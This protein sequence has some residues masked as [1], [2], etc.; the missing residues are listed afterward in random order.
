MS[1]FSPSASPVGLVGYGR[2]GAAFA[3]L[4]QEAGVRVW[5]LDPNG[6]PEH[7][8]VGSWAE[9][10][11]RAKTL[12]LATP[13]P[14]FEG[15]L[16]QL[17]PHLSAEHLV[18]DVGSVKEAPQAVLQQVL[19]STVPWVATHPLFGPASLARAER[20]IRVVVCPNPLHPTAH[21]RARALYEHVGCEV[22]EDDAAS[23][24]R[25]MADTHALTFF[26]TKGILEAGLYQDGRYAPPSFAAIERTLETVRADAGHLFLAIQHENPYAAATRKRL[27]EALSKVDQDL[28]ETEPGAYQGMDIPDLGPRT[29]QEPPDLLEEVDRELI[30]LLSRR[31]KLSKR[32][33]LD[34]AQRRAI[35]SERAA[36]AEAAGLEPRVIHAVLRAIWDT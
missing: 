1:G 28:Q 33:E 13:V 32:A 4:L 31:A 20:P 35:L 16:L 25:L 2:F 21:P 5:A 27:V 24:D 10:T 19:G 34:P 11:S 23:H 3:D 17:Q 14:T 26:V 29:S 30:A 12:V 15:V 9:L 36:Q 7:R 6:V 8:A 22:I 18:I